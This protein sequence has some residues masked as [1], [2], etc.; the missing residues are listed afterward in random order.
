MGRRPEGRLQR[1]ESEMTW[2]VDVEFRPSAVHGMGVF[3][4]RPIKAGAV[5]WKVDASMRFHSRGDLL[6]LPPARLAFALHGGYLHRPSDRFVWYEDGMQF[7]NHAPGRRANVG[8]DH[9]PELRADHT[10]AL[11]D[12]AAGEELYEDYGFWA[13]SG[14]GEEHWLAPLYR[15]ACPEH[16]GFLQS[17]DAALTAA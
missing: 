1:E 15:R 4:R 17:V 9:W 6:A 11:R 12:I 14:L 8:L 16:I 10:R 13:D 7:M 5:V 3:A 2:T